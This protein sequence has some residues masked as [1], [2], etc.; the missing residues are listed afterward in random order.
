MHIAYIG[1]RALLSDRFFFPPCI[2]QIK[3]FFFSL[4]CPP[5]MNVLYDSVIE[6]PTVS[7]R[8]DLWGQPSKPRFDPTSQRRRSIHHR[9]N[10]QRQVHLFPF[11]LFLRG[12][13][14]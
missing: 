10:S 9:Q 12:H 2:A 3:P 4:L 13:L 7:K 5:R 6:G 8:T 1:V 11:F 14:R